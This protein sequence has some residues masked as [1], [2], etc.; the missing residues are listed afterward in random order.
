MLSTCPTS[1]L[2]PITWLQTNKA[3]LVPHSL[4][5]GHGIPK[6]LSVQKAACIMIVM[7]DQ[8]KGNRPNFM[9]F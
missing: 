7:Q 6:R 3:N 4:E 2:A 8:I 5:T 1:H 9:Q